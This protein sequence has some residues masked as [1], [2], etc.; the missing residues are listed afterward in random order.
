MRAE[1]KKLQ[2]TLGITFVHV[3]HSQEEAMAL[4][5]IIVIMN[6]GKIEQAASPRQVFEK[7]ATAFVARFMGDHNVLSG[8]VTS[9]ENGVMVM[10]VPE[11][12]SFS[13]RGTGREVGEAVDIGIRT[14]RVRLQVA[15]EWTLGFNGIVSN[16]EYRGSSVKITVLGAGSDDFTV[17]ASDSDYFAKPV[18]VG[19]A[20][21]LSWALED[22][23]LLGRVSA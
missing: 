6:D 4:A 14:D 5:D 17:I 8:R 22:A 1:L 9:S 21:A 2:K 3:T 19:D 11:G 10:T 12:Q 20:V 13:V 18:S 16:I 15:T 23:V 7:P